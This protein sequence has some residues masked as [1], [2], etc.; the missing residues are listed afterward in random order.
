MV[1]LFGCDCREGAVL[2]SDLPDTGFLF[3]D[4]GFTKNTFFLFL[5]YPVSSDQRPATSEKTSPGDPDSGPED[6]RP[7]GNRSKAPPSFRGYQL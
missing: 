4:A 1:V 3:L 2:F 6:L 7:G 5:H